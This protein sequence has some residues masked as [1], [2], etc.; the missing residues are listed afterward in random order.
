MNTP[1]QQ[2]PRRGWTSAS[3]ALSDSLCP[4]RHLAQASVAFGLAE[5]E[6]DD[7]AFGRIVHRALALRSPEGLSVEQR[8]IYDGCCTIELSLI[9]KVFGPDWEKVNTFRE[10][11]TTGKGRYWVKFQANGQVFEHSAMPDVVHRLGN[12]ALIVEYKTL[13]G[14]VAESPKNLQLRDQA[15]VVAGHFIV[16]EIYV[17]VAQ[18]LVTMKEEECF[19]DSESLLRAEREL[20]ARVMASNQPNA[21]RHAGDVQC[22]FCTAKMGCVVYE[23]WA[24]AL[25]PGMVS[26]LDVPPDAWTP[27]QRTQFL[28]RAGAAQDWLDNCKAAIKQLMKTHSDAAPGYALRPGV[29]RESV[30]N[31]Q[32]VYIRFMKLGGT[33]ESF[34]RTIA[35]GKTKLKTEIQAVTGARGQALNAALDTLVKDCVTTST[36]EPTIVKVKP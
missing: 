24:S 33:V 4:G 34:M 27:A 35:V 19:Y 5:V 15:V 26:L 14:E 36:S 23:R 11:Q 18:P 12:R 8:E 9:K 20:F 28:E 2:D 30:N 7:A 32:E 29:S 6:S 1:T 17:A 10:D 16:T 13:R 21:E 25:V 22:K 3:N 31:P